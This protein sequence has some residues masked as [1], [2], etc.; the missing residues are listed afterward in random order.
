MNTYQYFSLLGATS[1]V[2]QS[3]ACAIARC[4]ASS[5][6]WSWYAGFSAMLST[7]AGKPC[8]SFVL[9]SHCACRTPRNKSKNTHRCEFS[10]GWILGK[11]SYQNEWRGTGT[12]WESYGV[13]IPEVFKKR[14]AVALRDV[15]SGH[16]AVDLVIL[17]SLRTKPPGRLAMGACSAAG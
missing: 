16:G 14:A 7:A 10:S 5:C 9:V 17:M 3:R 13:T 11:K 1:V 15:V 12:G 8:T 6:S 4:T 2:S